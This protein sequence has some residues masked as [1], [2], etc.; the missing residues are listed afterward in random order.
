MRKF[1]VA[2]RLKLAHIL[3]M[4]QSYHYQVIARALDYLREHANERPSLSQ[5]AEAQGLSP[6]HFQRVFSEWVGVS[7]KTYLEHLQLSQAKSLLRARIGVMQTAHSVGLSGTG[8]LHDLMIKWE[9]LTP[10]EFTQSQVPL[11][12]DTADTPFGEALF[13]VTDR[14]LTG[15][16]FT[17]G[18][19]ENTLSEY[20]TRCP[21]SAFIASQDM[22]APY[23]ERLAKQ[24]GE[25]P[26]TLVG[27]PFQHQVWRA[28]LEIPEGQFSTYGDIAG[29][30]ERP[31][32]ARA[33]GTAVG[34]NP[35]SWLIP[36]H[37]VIRQNGALGGYHW[38][39]ERKEAL[40]AYESAR[41]D[42]SSP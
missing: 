14:G 38:G 28:L 24:S 12:Y 10:G 21:N 36:C 8:R 16:A 37:R 34:Q 25:M 1:W 29:A 40:I 18:D 27:T 5:I 4:E 35:I 15:L 32:A 22:V 11:Y 23:V 7:P 39:V 19:A 26:V 17:N 41:Y 20:K 2:N 42:Q 33:V 30:V 6:Y 9:A 13:I 31:K 3:Y